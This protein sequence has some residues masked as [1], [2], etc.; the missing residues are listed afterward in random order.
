MENYSDPEDFDDNELDEFEDA[1]DITLPQD[2]TLERAVEEAQLAVNYFFNNDFDKAKNLLSP[3]SSVS[4]YHSLG[5]S[6]FLFLEAILTFEQNSIIEASKALKQSLIVCNR[7]R[8]KNTIGESLG[9][10][11]KK[12]NFDQFTELE[13]HAEL[14]HAEC[15]LL[16]SM[17]TFME[18]ETLSSFIKAG[19]KIRSC[20]NSY[21]DC[22][23]ILMKKTWNKDSTKVHFESG[24][25]MGIGTFNLMISML[26]SRVIKLLEFIGFSGNKQLGL[27][28]LH[29]GY[30]MDG[31]RQIL[32]I[33]TLLGY[34]LIVMHVLSH[35]EGDVKIC[36]EI[37]E[38]QLKKHPEGVWFLFFKG[39]LEFMKGD[40][41]ASLEWY[42]KSW[43]SQNVWPQFHH[44]CFWELLWVH[45]L[46]T[47]WRQALAFSTHLIEDSRWSKSL[48][49]YQKACIMIMIKDQLT[50]AELEEVDK[51]MKD[52]PKY[53]QRIAGKSLPM[54]K[55]A[56]K[57]SERY[58]AQNKTL[59]LPVLELMFLWNLF[60]IL[61]NFKVANNIFKLI[62]KEQINLNSSL[63]PSKYDTDNR[64]LILLLKG[65]CLRH[66]GSPL[67]ALECF[68]TVIQLQ[69]EIVEDT[70]V[71]P[72]AIVELALIEWQNGKREK[73]ILALEDAKKNYTGYS[74][75]SRLHFRIHTALSEYKAEL[76][77]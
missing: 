69:K 46:K 37:L 20:Y 13:A 76:K 43:K 64:A 71:V 61:K 5:S 11:V 35:R 9:K 34:N 45:C 23:Q 6:V 55:F 47:E 39:R 74:L 28:D 67:Q 53:K 10:M 59:I 70:Y 36:E 40:L 58:F 77:S 54:E 22:Q 49:S 57:K 31:I 17:L 38:K 66:M 41:D 26:P 18:D 56:V 2:M 24:V 14:C 52:V 50:P 62:E 4:I 32:C 68:E 63:T 65:A 8:K 44:I 7:F 19:I 33:M 60:K 73:A 72:Y 15:L 1:N 48:Y 25:K 29:K 75:E 21:K 30:R 42:T 3:Y 27:D 12:N 16:K 51:L